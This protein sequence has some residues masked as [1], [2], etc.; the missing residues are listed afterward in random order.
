MVCIGLKV[1]TYILPPEQAPGG[2]PWGIPLIYP[3]LFIS[4]AALVIVS[5][6]TPPPDEKELKKMFG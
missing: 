2:D 1:L 4:V 6:L 5:Y 3:A